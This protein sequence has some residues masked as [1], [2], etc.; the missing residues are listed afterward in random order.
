MTE[1]NLESRE[2]FHE[3]RIVTGNATVAYCPCGWTA[4]IDG[5]TSGN[6]VSAAYRA[7]LEDTS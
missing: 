7:H 6:D 2:P 1:P 5:P 4:F 3:L